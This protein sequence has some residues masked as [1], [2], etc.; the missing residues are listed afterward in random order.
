MPRQPRIH[1]PGGF[2]HVTLR[3]NHQQDI[4]VVPKDRALLNLIVGRVLPKY[5]VRLHAY[6]WMRNHLHFLLQ[7]SDRPLAGPMG[8]IAKEFA[9]SMQ[10]KLATSGHFFERRYHATLVEAESYFKEVI[11]YIHRN[12]V[13]AGVVADPSRFPWSSHHAYCGARVESWLTTDFALSLF[14]STRRTAIAAYREFVAA[15]ADPALVLSDSTWNKTAILGSE[16]FIARVRAASEPLKKCPVTLEEIVREACAR[17]EVAPEKLLS[18]VRDS[19]LS[20]VRAWVAHQA[21]KRNATTMAG[22]ARYLG[23]DESTLREAIKVHAAEV[24]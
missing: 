17:F 9:R 20:Q 10:E 7:V 3:G 18:R 12:P 21:V 11:R 8:Q 2:Y 6:C 5:G 15:P 23:R 24:E 19:Y 22:V 1:L 4:F 16:E 14:G 13:D